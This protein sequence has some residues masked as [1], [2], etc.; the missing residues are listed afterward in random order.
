MHSTKTSKGEATRAAALDQAADLAS[1]IGLQALSIGSLADELGMSKSGLF[2]H[3]G[4]K[5]ALQVQT[6]ERAAD[7][8]T[9]IVVRPALSIAPGEPRVRALFDGWMDWERARA[10][11]GCIFIQSSAEFDDQPGAVR[12]TLER[13]QRQWLEFLA[14][15]ANRAVT[16]G[17]FRADLDCDQFAFEFYALL[18]GYGHSHRMMRDPAARDRL[19]VGFERLVSSA[20]ANEDPA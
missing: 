15:A 6:L 16:V 7:A 3:F 9:E 1:R 14:G 4:S 11:K 5:E 17:H 8:F 19:K 18:I 20:R 10:M 2:A 12:D 13:Q